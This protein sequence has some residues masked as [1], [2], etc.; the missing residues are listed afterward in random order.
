MKE[1]HQH[2][3]SEI[4]VSDRMIILPRHLPSAV[5]AC[6]KAASSR[7]QWGKCVGQKKEW[8]WPNAA[9]REDIG[10]ENNAGLISISRPAPTFLLSLIYHVKITSNIVGYFSRNEGKLETGNM[11]LKLLDIRMLTFW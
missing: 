11:S 2:Y 6:T 1:L 5:M 3:Q 9:E 10:G 8:S 7:R 4:P